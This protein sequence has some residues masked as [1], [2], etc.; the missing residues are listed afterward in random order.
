MM[1]AWACNEFNYG[2][3]FFI[4]EFLWL[5]C[6]ADL[7]SLPVH[8]FNALF[9]NPQGLLAISLYFP[10][11]NYYNCGGSFCFMSW[12]LKFLCCWHLMYVFI[13]LVKFR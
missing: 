1:I 13:F 10:I 3:Y 11:S 9:S 4:S 6:V 5:C 7:K 8:P 12:C 2:L